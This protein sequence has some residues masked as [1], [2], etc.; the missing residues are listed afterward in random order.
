MIFEHLTDHHFKG[1]KEFEDHKR[2]AMTQWHY[3]V[4]DNMFEKLEEILD[5]K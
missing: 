2:K 3:F 5:E 1:P 4:R